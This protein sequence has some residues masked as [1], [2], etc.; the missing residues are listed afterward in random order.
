MPLQSPRASKAEEG[1]PPRSPS[2]ASFPG[3]SKEDCERYADSAVE[4]DPTV[5]FMMEKLGEVSVLLFSIK[6]LRRP[7]PGLDPA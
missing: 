2:T 4:R 5:K 1:P 7:R 6:D 3:S